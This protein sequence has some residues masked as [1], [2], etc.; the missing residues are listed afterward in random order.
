[1]FEKILV[2]VD[3]SAHSKRALTAAAD[4]A[5]HY[6]ASVYLLHV[7]RDL[8][9]PKEIW[10]MI[11]AGEVTESRL[12]ILEDSAEIILDN[13]RQ[14]LAE[15][16]LEDVKAQYLVGDPAVKIASYAEEQAVDL[17]IIGHRGLGTHGEMLGSVARKLLNFTPVPCL[18]VR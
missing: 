9:L 4:L 7:I 8:S 1:M 15:A 11:S 2:A 12:E 13:G 17:I 14:Q 10:E 5:R 6:R 18:V 3:G 16:G